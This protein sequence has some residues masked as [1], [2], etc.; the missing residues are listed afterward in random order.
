MK[1]GGSKGGTKGWKEL[2]T[3]KWAGGGG[4]RMSNL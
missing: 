1:D 3:D 2:E 4:V